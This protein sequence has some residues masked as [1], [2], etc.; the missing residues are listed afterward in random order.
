MRSAVLL[1]VSACL[2]GG[3][4][5]ALQ[6][7]LPGDVAVTLAV[8][9][10]LGTRSA[11]AGWLTDTARAPMLWGTIMIAALLAYRVS[12]WR[13]A[14]AAPLAYGLA[15]VADKAFRAVIFAPRPDP[16][17]IAV[18]DP[19]A[20]SGLPSTFGLVYAAMFGAAL[21][22]KG[23]RRTWPARTIAAA[24]IVAGCT[25]RVAL[26][27]HWPSQ[28]AASATF[29]LM[30]ALGALALTRRMMPPGRK[31]RRRVSRV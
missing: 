5:L 18:A 28:I 14:V 19:S 24:L 27:G 30:L 20:S 26:G 21:L 8:Q 2:V 12:G 3:A 13:G 7:P 22:A 25:A 16:A 9:D 29:G 15:F 6:G 17:L 10:A 23:H 4:S 1:A 11:W 31:R